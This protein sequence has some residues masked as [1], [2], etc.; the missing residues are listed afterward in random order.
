MAP[1]TAY[2]L[3]ESQVT[4]PESVVALFWKLARRHRDSFGAVLDMGAGDCR[5]GH[6]APVRRY[7]GVEIDRK[8]AS[9]AC[10]PKNGTLLTGCVFKH[11]GD[12]Y[13]ACIGNP[14]YVRHHDIQTS[15]KDRTVG[16][17]ERVLGV[18]LNQ[19]C[20]LYI[21]FCV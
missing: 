16:H 11:T 9:V 17:I 6:G 4:T 2:E 10:P 12:S 8:R 1:R 21:T 14:P 15:W 3:S 18:S 20:N 5:F 7:V 19:H 13:D